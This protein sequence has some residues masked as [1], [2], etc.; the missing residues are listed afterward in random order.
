LKAY[1]ELLKEPNLTP[2]VKA[3]I[4]FECSQLA[5]SLKKWKT[6][7]KHALD[8]G[9]SLLPGD[10]RF[11][12]VVIAAECLY[13]MDKK[14]K[15]LK[16]MEAILKK[17]GFSEHGPEVRLTLA[18]WYLEDD[19][20]KDAFDLL[21]NITL[22][23]PRTVYAAEAY[24]RMGKYV[25]EKEVDETRAMEYFD[26]SAAC[27]DT[28]EFSAL[29]SEKAASL[30]KLNELRAV[31]DS[32]DTAGFRTDF[33]MAELF[34]FSLDNFDSAMSHMN[35]IVT[36]YSIKAAYA[37]AFM[38]DEFAEAD[39]GTDSLYQYV[40]D[41]YPNTE[42]AKQAEINMGKVPSVVTEED[43]AHEL[44]LDAEEIFFSGY[45]LKEKVIP[46][47][48]EVV[49][50]FPNTQ[51]AAQAL[52]VIAMLHERNYQEGD[53][54]SLYLAK[55]THARIRDNYKQSEFFPVSNDKLLE[56]GIK[57]GDEI[58][59]DVPDTSGMDTADVSPA[60]PDAAKKKSSREGSKF[61]HRE[62]YRRGDLEDKGRGYYPEEEED[63]EEV[64]DAGEEDE[65]Y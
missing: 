54:Y 58:V 53:A 62:R 48:S 11:R 41:R 27:G 25:L 44:F 19:R 12:S 42:Y 9:I 29:S 57:P 14:Q 37:R 45:D 36:G 4:I 32:S 2:K 64:L 63:S 30:R 17:Y 7:R 13:F 35:K 22:K 47:Y 40:M 31:S 43:E 56:A 18:K 65:E 24:Y 50:K 6:A 20:K 55:K 3:A 61:E 46:K 60:S 26:S 52:F 21:E 23:V 15:A 49:E 5:Y 8:P 10:M 38:Y 39:S 1:E 28:L 59:P 33:Y 34:L 16:E 51:S